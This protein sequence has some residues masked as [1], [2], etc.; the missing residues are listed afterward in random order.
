LHRSGTALVV[1]LVTALGAVA[2][3]A[4]PPDPSSPPGPPPIEVSPPKVVLA[5]LDAEIGVRATAYLGVGQTPV[6]IRDARG[7]VRARGVLDAV[8]RVALRLEGVRRGG[9]YDVF[10]PGLY[11][12]GVT[13]HLRVVPGWLSLLPPVLAILLALLFRQVVPAL[14]AGVWLGASIVSG[15]PLTGAL[16]TI[17][18]YVIHALADADHV[19]I[20]VFSLM[21]GGMV[22]IMARAGGTVGLVEAL[23]PYAT[24]TRRGQVVTWI[25]GILVF[26]DD[27]AN[28]LLVGNTMRPVTDRLRVSREKLSYIVDSTAAPV[29]AIGI[30]ST[31]IGYEVSLIGDALR[32]VGSSRDAYAVF[33]QSI[34]YNFYPILALAFGLMVAGSLRDFGPMLRAERR[35]REG[36]LLADAAVPLSDFDSESLRPVESR[37]HR[38]PNA[39][40]P[41]LVV[42]AVT[43]LGLWL[44]GR[45]ALAAEGSPLA[46]AGLSQL[47]FEGLGRVFGSGDS[48]RALLWG[49]SSGCLTAL[50]LAMTQRILT[51]GESLAAWLHGIRSMVIAVVILILAWSIAAVCADL[52][53]SGF[54]VAAVSDALDPRLLPAL[55]FALAA[56]TAF[57]TGTS[58]GTMGILIPL[59]VPTAHGVAQAAGLDPAAAHG[60][61]LGGISSVLAGAIFG[62]HCSP[63]S[64]TTV[65]SSMASGCDH[66]DHVRTQL[67]Y[68]IAVALVAV[69]TGYLP[70]AFGLPT[71]LCLLLGAAVLGAGLAVF[72]R[73]A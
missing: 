71:P 73:R 18:G 12:Q 42:L 29:A 49:S 24:N 16:R 4:T 44:T 20:I 39:V 32:Q 52:H 50:L 5:G 55:V 60:I 66:V 10:L 35:A 14:V 46:G 48:F 19:S 27:Y 43:F 53:T 37:P 22:G 65:M 38:W 30:V 21:L 3:E 70:A 68:A 28:T 23:R 34:P 67:P 61:L 59:A 15:G 8:N 36:K 1:V 40:V 45:H 9:S 25:L 69:V 11:R 51:L 54:M 17:D 64:D 31:W 6:E 26:F 13:F 47:G 57:A 33:L 2:G 58:W 72:G 63:I 7:T 56:L 41:V 62:D